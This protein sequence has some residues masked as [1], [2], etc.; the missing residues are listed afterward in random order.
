[1]L[2]KWAVL[3]SIHHMHCTPPVPAAIALMMVGKCVPT[4]RA[5]CSAPEGT[6]THPVR[7]QCKPKPCRSLSHSCLDLNSPPSPT[8]LEVNYIPHAFHCSW[9]KEQTQCIPY[10]WCSSCCYIQVQ[11][12]LEALDKTNGN[13]LYRWGDAPVHTMVGIVC[14]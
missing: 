13:Y 11:A 5:Q 2:Y 7:S 4:A 1:V 9:C 3:P 10:L 6:S 14:G 12:Y 8:S